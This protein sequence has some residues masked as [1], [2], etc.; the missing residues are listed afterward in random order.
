[1]KGLKLIY[2]IPKQWFNI[3]RVILHQMSINRQNWRDNRESEY[4]KNQSVLLWKKEKSKRF[5]LFMFGLEDREKEL[6]ELINSCTD[7]DIEKMYINTFGEEDYS[8]VR[9]VTVYK[10]D[11]PNWPFTV[12]KLTIVALADK[13]VYCTFK[14][15]GTEYD[16]ALN[17]WSVDK[18]KLKSILDSKFLK[19]D[20][21]MTSISKLNGGDVV[22]MPIDKYINIGYDLFND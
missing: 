21:E 5:E 10:K 4:F 17:G 22:H 14:S 15:K 3:I 8:L 7:K 1:M 6:F 12:N 11:Y 16:F 20:E 9:K 2:L 19:I 18:L 13:S